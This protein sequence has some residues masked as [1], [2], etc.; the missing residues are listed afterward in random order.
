MGRFDGLTDAQWQIIE[1]QLL[2]VP[3]KKR[4]RPSTCTLEASM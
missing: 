4:E 2:K 1:Y 3:E